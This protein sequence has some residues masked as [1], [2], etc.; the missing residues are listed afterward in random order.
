MI[1]GT[2]INLYD[3][4]FYSLF[5]LR[6]CWT[7]NCSLKN[8][9]STCTLFAVIW[10]KCSMLFIFLLY[11]WRISAENQLY[12]SQISYIQV[13]FQVSFRHTLPSQYTDNILT[14]YTIYW[15]VLM[16]YNT[17]LSQAFLSNWWWSITMTTL[18]SSDACSS[19]KTLWST[20]VRDSLPLR[21]RS[22]RSRSSLKVR[23]SGFMPVWLRRNTESVLRWNCDFGVFNTGRHLVWLEDEV[24]KKETFGCEGQISWGQG[25]SVIYLFNALL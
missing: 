20:R 17:D 3:I 2:K 14:I 18:S 7:K 9:Y 22:W 12:P 10:M 11:I 21:W 5:L 24:W 23:W 25:H 13:K 16:Y 6:H 1:F 8:N 4:N 15:H 19:A